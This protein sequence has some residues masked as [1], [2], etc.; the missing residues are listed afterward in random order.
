MI[1]GHVSDVSDAMQSGGSM[2][3]DCGRELFREEIRDLIARSE[4]NDQLVRRA[5]QLIDSLARTENPNGFVPTWYKRCKTKVSK[6][7]EAMLVFSDPC[8][9]ACSQRYVACAIIASTQGT[10]SIGE[11]HRALTDLA[12]SW[13]SNFLWVCKFFPWIASWKRR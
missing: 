1:R 13:F 9:G 11:T 5:N 12:L 3:T 2:N 4:S 6:I 7:I 10:K 8:G